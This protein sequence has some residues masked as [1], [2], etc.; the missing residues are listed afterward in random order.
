[1]SYKVGVGCIR[2]GEDNNSTNNK[3][4]RRETVENVCFNFLCHRNQTLWQLA[5]VVSTE[6]DGGCS[7][8]HHISLGFE[9][10]VTYSPVFG[11]KT[12]EHFFSCIN[13]MKH[14]LSKETR[15]PGSQRGEIVITAMRPG[16]RF[17]KRR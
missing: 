12:N 8:R 3:R 2:I 1:M 11:S 16:Q 4:E 13:S 10:F 6:I 14:M 15:P 17:K 5:G 9:R 7:S